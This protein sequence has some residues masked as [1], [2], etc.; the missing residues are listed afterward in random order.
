[1]HINPVT[2]ISL[3]LTII[4]SIWRI[5]G[6]AI[7]VFIVNKLLSKRPANI[8]YLSSFSAL[9][10]VL[11]WSV[12]SFVS[13]RKQIAF[14]F[15]PVQSSIVSQGTQVLEPTTG[16]SLEQTEPVANLEQEYTRQALDKS[17]PAEEKVPALFVVISLLWFS[18][19]CILAIRLIMQMIY[20]ERFKRRHKT[21]AEARLL[22]IVEDLRRKLAVSKAVQ[23]FE[24]SI[25]KV[26]MVIGIFK[27]AI[28]LP[29][30]VISGLK[31]EQIELILAHELAHVKRYDYFF[32]IIQTVIETLF[33]Y[34]PAIW[35]ISKQI[36]KERENACDDIA[37]AV[38]G[39][40]TDYAQALLELEQ[41]R[42]IPTTA[43]SSGSNLKTRL[44]RLLGVANNKKP[45]PVGLIAGIW[46]L[47]SISGLMFYPGSAAAMI[48]DADAPE[49]GSEPILDG[50][51]I[52]WLTEHKEAKFNRF[53][54]LKSIA[55]GGYLV[56]E[57]PLSRPERKVIV[58][59]AAFGFNYE[60]FIDGEKQEDAKLGKVW[61]TNVLKRSNFGDKNLALFKP[62]QYPHSIIESWWVMRAPTFG[63][64]G[65]GITSLI[66]DNKLD[67]D[68]ANPRGPTGRIISE[69]DLLNYLNGNYYYIS[70]VKH[71]EEGY[72]K[73]ISNL[74]RYLENYEFT[75]NAK[76]VL[77][78]IIKKIDNH[79]D[80]LALEKQLNAK[81][82]FPQPKYIYDQSSYANFREHIPYIQLYRGFFFTSLGKY[83][84][85]KD[86]KAIKPKRDRGYV[87]I[88]EP[89]SEPRK[90]LIIANHG[91]KIDMRY[92]EDGNEL[93]FGQ[94]DENWLETAVC[95]IQ[96][97]KAYDTCS[98]S[99]KDEQMWVNALESEKYDGH[100][101]LY[102]HD[103]YKGKLISKSYYELVEEE[104]GELF[105][106]EHEHQE[107]L[108]PISD[109]LMPYI[110]RHFIKV[111]DYYDEFAP[112]EVSILLDHLNDIYDDDVLADI[113]ARLEP[114]LPK[115]SPS[116][117]Q[118]YE[119]LLAT[120]PNEDRK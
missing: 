68:L 45:N 98:Y 3:A 88:E 100:I 54:E 70:H 5:A 49:L 66:F 91:G 44:R 15:I 92:F 51:E 79:N 85:S 55:P 48:I 99:T 93:S 34:H 114:K 10:I 20:A 18:G 59:N 112:I 110:H 103:T 12:F 116:T 1:M 37:I 30:T 21:K 104:R 36:R 111:I 81:K 96:N 80:R 87:I 28:I 32:N 57:Q 106:L 75:A 60:Y 24:S 65:L 4:F 42:H 117:M 22:Q 58:R 94:K 47:F 69:E 8:R 13:F 17:P 101:P 74:P 78:E 62:H 109:S 113:L 107:F 2:L 73:Y 19:V 23:L 77:A 35:W 63:T 108:M 7:V 11:L 83:E 115:D 118:E 9:L 64:T 38:T 52:Y 39:S 67:P 27:P 29:I 41:M 120:I 53:H 72:Q 89:L 102:F 56:L 84:I 86:Y 50:Y 40:A 119:A 6:I 97:Y 90:K 82:V 26:P 61:F 76:I 71:S 16:T 31:L 43:M 46:L 95:A 105:T 25:A 33:F 14:Y